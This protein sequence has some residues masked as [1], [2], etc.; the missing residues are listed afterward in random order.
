MLPRGFL[1][2]VL[3]LGISFFTFTQIAYHID[4]RQDIAKR[5]D[6]LSYTVFVAFF[7]HLIAGPIIH[8][9][10]LM[11]QFER[12]PH[13]RHSCRTI[14]RWAAA[15]L[16]WGWPR[17]CCWRTALRRW[18]MRSTP[19]HMRPGFATS[20]LG[21]LAYSAQL[22]FDFS[23]Y[24][25]MAVA[26]AKM[27]SIDFPVNFNSPFKAACIIDFWQRWHMTLSRYLQEYLYSPILSWVNGRR[28]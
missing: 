17:K 7:P 24:S 11:P 4:L 15:G 23:G 27:F 1:E 13:P 28:H 12:G 2:L 19:T 16:S 10:E 14:S 21:A 6:L 8:P 5:Q 25:D 9:R 26:L 3:P 22:Y 20:W 18:P